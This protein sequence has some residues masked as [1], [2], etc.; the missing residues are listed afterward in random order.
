MTA[1]TV[2]E[3]VVLDMP[4]HEYHARPE[5]SSTGAR[6]I[7]ES[8]AKFQ[9]ALTHPEPPRDA[10]DLGSLVHA[11]VLGVGAQA[12]E[13]PA[14][15][16]ATNGAASTAAAKQFIAEARAAGL[17]P[18]KADVLATVDAMA[19]AVLAHATARVLFEQPGHPEVS[20]FG[21]DPVTGVEVRARFDYRPEQGDRP[22]GVDLKTAA[23]ASPRGFATAAARHGYH[24]Q[25]GH[26]LDTNRFAGGHDLAEFL[27]VVVESEPPHLVGVYQ[28]DHEFADMG[29]VRARRA[30]EVFAECTE[31][32]IWP[33]YPMNVQ[34]LQPPVWSIYE[35]QETYE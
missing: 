30:R 4:E 31:T 17:I 33:G 25:R 20:V 35:H 18:V 3:N 22:I 27:F 28:L 29:R 23:D 1:G 21:A 12:V 7:L 5:L 34:L 26:Y 6:R 10:F 15:V 16:L 14:E 19:E 24:V 11:K 32:G 2:T 9:Y 13:I 8:P